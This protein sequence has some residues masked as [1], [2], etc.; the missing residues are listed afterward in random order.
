MAYTD[1]LLRFSDAQTITG[2]SPLL[3]TNTVDTA[4]ARDIGQGESLKVVF[5][6]GT[7]FSGLTALECQIIQADDAAL[8]TNVEVLGS[9]GPIE[10][11]AL[12]AGAGFTAKPGPLL[13]GRRARRYLGVRYVPTGSGTSGTMTASIESATESGKKLYGGGFTVA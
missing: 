2:S 11:A 12:V 6:V 4:N 8:T 3:S 9:T 5:R 13:Q 7:S 1:A 10:L